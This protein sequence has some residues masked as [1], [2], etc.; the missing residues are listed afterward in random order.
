MLIDDGVSLLLPR[1]ECNGAILAHCNLCFPG[2]SDFPASASRVP[3]TTELEFHHVGQAGLELR[4]SGDQ[5]ILASQSSGITSMSHHYQ[6]RTNAFRRGRQLASVSALCLSAMEG[7]RSL[8]LKCNSTI[9]AHCNLHLPGSGD[10]PP[11]TASRVAGITGAHHY[12]WLIFCTFSRDGVS[13]RWSGWSRTPNLRAGT[14]AEEKPERLVSPDRDKIGIFSTTCKAFMVDPQGKLCRSIPND[15]L[16]TQRMAN[17]KLECN[18]TI[19]AHCNLCL[20]DSASPVAG[21]RSM[22]HNAWLIL[23]FLVEKEFCH[24]AQAG[25]QFLTS[26][27]PP[28]STSQSTGITGVSH[29]TQPKPSTLAL[30]SHTFY[31]NNWDRV[32]PR[33]SVVANFWFMD[34]TQ[35]AG[36]FCRAW[37]E[38]LK[39]I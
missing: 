12:A 16:L 9:L 32:R 7:S 10:S 18:G 22:C 35:D 36:T 21:I 6:P 39:G 33:S 27:D 8:L 20:P 38:F 15:H 1:L 17:R 37:I 19:S 3:E 13:Q 34:R 23:V 11:A 2:S 29:H 4:T 26:S 5:P 24:V 25:F 28:H 30:F 31:S 14:G